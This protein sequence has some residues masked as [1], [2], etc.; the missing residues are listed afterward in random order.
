MVD[1]GVSKDAL[2]AVIPLTGEFV[3][4]TDSQTL[5]T[6]TIST[7]DNT[8]TATSQATGDILKNNGTSFVRL[9]RGSANQP[10]KV[11]SGGTDLDYGTLPVAGGGTGA[12]TL[13]GI[14]KGSGTSAFTAVTAPTGAIVGDSDTQTLSGKTFTN[15]GAKLRN[16][17]N[18]FT[19]TILNP[20]VTA[21]TDIQLFFDTPRN[22]IYIGADGL[23]KVKNTATGAITSSSSVNT[24]FSTAFTSG[25]DG[26]VEVREGVYPITGVI[27]NLRLQQ[28]V[29]LSK[30]AIIEVPNGYTG[31]VFSF[32]NTGG[33]RHAI[34]EGGQIRE[35]TSVAAQRLW[36]AIELNS[37]TSAGVVDNLIMNVD[38]INAGT[39][40]LLKCD[41]STSFVNANSICHNNMNFCKIFF[42]FQLANSGVKINANLFL[43][44]RLQSDANVD[45]GFKNVTGSYNS[46]IHNYV[47]DMNLDGTA[48]SMNILSSALNT[49]IIGGFVTHQNFVDSTS[50]VNTIRME[51]GIGIN[52]LQVPVLVNNSYHDMNVISAPSSPST[53]TV[54][55]YSKTIDSNNDGNFYKARINGAVVEV[56][57]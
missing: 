20:A 51:G 38:I 54:R 43:D 16:P 25:N 11:N 37:T 3:G 57:I 8:L 33:A 56:Q 50:P 34:L 53:G 4:T 12:A 14:L 49:I 31:I 15:Q 40:I 32:N 22:I 13:T 5:T 47:Y 30:G 44:N 23:Y 2:R 35:N 9:A 52:G 19:G 28:H 39:G 7:T 18:T 1:I 29:I 17:A 36:T 24:T 6:K 48:T 45:Y 55:R 27:S 21:D 46:F 10:L 26:L 41:G 42:D